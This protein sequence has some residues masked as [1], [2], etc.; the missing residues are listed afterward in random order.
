MENIKRNVGIYAADLAKQGMVI[1]LGSGST[2]YWLIQELGKRVQQG[3]KI[4]AV[5]TSKVTA[6]LAKEVGISLTDLN[7]VHA[8]PLTIDGADEI[9]GK[10]QL[11]KGGGGALLQE[12]IVAGA[13]AKLVIIADNSKLVRH[14]GKFPLPVEVIPFG[15]E[16]VQRRIVEMG[17]C[18]KISLRKKDSDIFIT[19]HH[20]YIMDCEC[21]NISD[22]IA[23]NISLHLIPGVVET[24][25]F[26]NMAN[27][28]VIGFDDGRVEVINYR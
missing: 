21:E 15:Y 6:Q 28:A 16:H 17:I 22:P 18:K 27:Q 19:D 24:G 14:L 23:F 26:I 12:K 4:S 8:L 11:I 1:G 3:L 5:P 7:E 10:G 20:N 2:V 13:S 25:L 9:D